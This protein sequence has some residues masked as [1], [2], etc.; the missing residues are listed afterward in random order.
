[1]IKKYDNY[2]KRIR[3][4]KLLLEMDSIDEAPQYELPDGYEFVF[5]QPGDRDTWIEIEQSAKEFDS[6][7]D[8]RKGWKKYFEGKDHELVNRMF[9][10]VNEDGKK[11]GTASAFYDIYGKDLSG[12]GWVHWVSVRREYQGQGLARPL[13]SHALKILKSLG[14]TKAKVPTQTITWLACKLY[15][16]FGFY[17]ERENVKE[18]LDGWRVIKTLTNHPKLEAF[19]PTNIE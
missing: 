12:A 13:I 2:D 18:N 3:F 16:D 10:I 5:Y 11:V 14:Y 4:Y 7:E 15:L 8:G 19:E 6:Y 9:F 1:M 17:P